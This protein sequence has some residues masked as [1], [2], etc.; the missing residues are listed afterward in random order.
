MFLVSI[1]IFNEKYST[2]RILCYAEFC[3]YV[4]RIFYLNFQKVFFL[5]SSLCYI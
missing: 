1:D 3:D 2:D 5:R 4:L